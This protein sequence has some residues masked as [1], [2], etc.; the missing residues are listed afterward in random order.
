MGGMLGASD[1]ETVIHELFSRLLTNGDLRRA[2][3][4]G[5]FVAWLTT[6]ARNQA[7]DYQRR[8]GREVPLEDEAPATGVA[9]WAEAAEARVL[10]ERFRR[11]R[12]P[13]EWG[14]VFERRFLEQMTQHE[15]ARALGIRRTTLAYRELRIRRAL[16]DFL[17]EDDDS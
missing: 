8:R 12:L 4:G 6:V 9:S 17:L 10:I 11:E 3:T 5:S 2:F 13:R 1:R 15:A 14:G 16:R 7:I